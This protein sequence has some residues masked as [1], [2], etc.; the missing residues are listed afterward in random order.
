V[1][2]RSLHRAAADGR[3]IPVLDRLADESSPGFGSSLLALVVD[4]GHRVLPT[5]GQ[6]PDADN[7]VEA[8]VEAMVPGAVETMV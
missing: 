6:S 1:G 4:R 8:M 5:R 2:A 7:G 3:R